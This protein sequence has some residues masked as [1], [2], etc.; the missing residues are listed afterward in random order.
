[1]VKLQNNI[2]IVKINMGIRCN[3]FVFVLQCIQRENVHNWNRRRAPWEPLLIFS[4]YFSRLSCVQSCLL[5]ENVT[6]L[7]LSTIRLCSLTRR[8]WSPISPRFSLARGSPATKQSRFDPVLRLKIKIWS[9]S[10][11]KNQDLIRFCD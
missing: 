6:Y 5:K 3:F 9:G 4:D 11:T 8:M 1:M 7:S 10:L 2:D